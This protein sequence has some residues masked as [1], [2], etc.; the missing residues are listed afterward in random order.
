[1]TEYCVA[2]RNEKT[3][4][5]DERLNRPTRGWVRISTFTSWSD[6][7]GTLNSKKGDFAPTTD[8]AIFQSI[9]TGCWFTFEPVQSEAGTQE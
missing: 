7:V 4:K 9:N 8:V 6:A 1:M 5:H 3:I 2:Y